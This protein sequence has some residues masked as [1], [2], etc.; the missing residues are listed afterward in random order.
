TDDQKIEEYAQCRKV[1]FHGRTRCSRAEILD[2]G[3]D[4]HGVERTKG[5][6]VGLAPVRELPSCLEV[7]RSRVRVPDPSREELG[8]AKPSFRTR[9]Q[10]E[11]WHV[12]GPRTVELTE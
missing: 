8:E 6:M 7:R 9:V 11:R 4:N 5:N 1:L 3:R 12:L 2:V 10:E